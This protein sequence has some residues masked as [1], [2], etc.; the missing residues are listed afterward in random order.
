MK[1]HLELA[2]DT[3]LITAHG[4]GWVEVARQRQ[5]QNF[6]LTPKEGVRGAWGTA[7]WEAL[8]NED[9]APLLCASPEL[10]LLASGPHMRLPPKALLQALVASGVGFEIM[11]L[12][13]ACRTYNVVASEGRRVVAAFVL[14]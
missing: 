1:L 3:Y 12:G 11:G 14:Q 10:I 9:L 7:G 13:A 5:T 4:D 6:W 8:S 2:A